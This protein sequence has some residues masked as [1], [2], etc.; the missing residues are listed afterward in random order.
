M[1][2]VKFLEKADSILNNIKYSSKI[3]EACSKYN[4]NAQTGVIV[5]NGNEG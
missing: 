4:E 5:I 1:Y 2:N 3:D